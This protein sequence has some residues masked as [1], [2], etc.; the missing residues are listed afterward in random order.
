MRKARIAISD[1]QILKLYSLMRNA[2]YDAFN[3]AFST[4]CLSTQRQAEAKQVEAVV[5][6]FSDHL[7]T[8]GYE[9]TT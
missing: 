4:P 9:R 3:L 7:A 1:E 6:V 5:K 2:D 8:L